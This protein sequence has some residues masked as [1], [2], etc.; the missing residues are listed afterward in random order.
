MSVVVIVNWGIL[1]LAT[2]PPATVVVVAPLLLV[3]VVVVVIG[4]HLAGESD[5]GTTCK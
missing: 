2:T 5:S 3:L 1:F 4:L